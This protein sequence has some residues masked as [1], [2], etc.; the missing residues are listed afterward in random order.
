MIAQ[1]SSF[2][3]SMLWNRLVVIFIGFGVTGPIT[4]SLFMG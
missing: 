1:A 3:R 4:N 2:R